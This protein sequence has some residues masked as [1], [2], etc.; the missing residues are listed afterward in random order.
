MKNIA[1]TFDDG[2]NTST[3]PL[4]LEKLQKYAVP[5]SFFLI[6]NNITP[7]SAAVSRAAFERGCE[8]CSHS[9]SHPSMPGLSEEEIRAE[10]EFTDCKIKEITGA[11]PRFFRP[12]YIAVN[13]VML[14]VIDKIFIA[15][16]GAE[17]WLDEVTS[18]MRAEKIL[19]QAKNGSII[20]LHDMEG[21]DKTVA[22]LDLIIPALLNGGYE[23]LTVSG[24]FAAEGV[25]PK[26]GIIYSNV[27]QTEMY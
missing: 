3:T 9:R 10:I 23:F 13:D 14:G 11:A 7:E 24:L 15:G 18:R 8:I 6:G 19:S 20:L 17:D 25:E 21:N 27:L 2:P 16:I 1:L 12:P 5:A 4:V 26:R 22:A